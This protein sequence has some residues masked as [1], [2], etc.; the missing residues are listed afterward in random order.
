MSSSGTVAHRPP[1]SGA[2]G[3]GR[4]ALIAVSPRACALPLPELN[5]P[6]GREW[7]ASHELTDE[8][9]SGSHLVFSRGGGVL[10]VQDAGSRN[11]T[12]IDG[13]PL[14]AKQN[15]PVADGA[16]LRIGKTLL[17]YRDSLEGDLAA[18]EPLAEMIGPFGLRAVA[19]VAQSLTHTQPNNVLIE[20]ETGTGKELAAAF[21]AATLGR[22]KP[23]AAINA[24]SVPAGVFESQLFGHV[25]G[26]FTE[27]KQA[28]KGLIVAHTGGT[29]F[30]DEIGELSLDLQPK[31]LRLL[32]NREIL[33][34]GGERPVKVDVLLVAATNRSLGEMVEAGS[35]RRDLWARFSRAH[36]QLPPL[37][38]RTEDLFAIAQEIASKSG[39][40]LDAAECE[41]EAVELMLLHDWPNNIRELAGVLD[42]ARAADPAP[43]LR[44]WSVAQA[45]GDAASGRGPV[46]T[47]DNVI[48]AIE[49]C[50]GNKALAA[51]RL[52]ITRGK[53][54]RMLKKA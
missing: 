33:P 9:V 41:V 21:V 32:E 12:W 54:L 52:G 23:F 46:L 45:L 29:V 19:R 50:G 49:A 39:Q 4:P 8:E 22:S 13:Q 40:S 6:V 18:A 43:G 28:A 53:L 1:M 5:K 42:R 36:V 16:V 26:A 51:E 27:A 31:L 14:P 24:A 7:L 37:R 20:G 3:G 35:F 2:S 30:L 10:R 38:Q 34:V 15:V 11:G 25:A 17:V 48:A 44:L 47:T